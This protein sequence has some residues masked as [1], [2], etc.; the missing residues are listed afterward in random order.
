MQYLRNQAGRKPDKLQAIQSAAL[1]TANMFINVGLTV[2]KL[3]PLVNRLQT[4][5]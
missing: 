5:G 3:I 1:G 4:F 2:T